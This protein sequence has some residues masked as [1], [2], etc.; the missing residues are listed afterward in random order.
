MEKYFRQQGSITV[1]MALTFPTFLAAIG[2]F[3][4]FFQVFFIQTRMETAIDTVGSKC[5]AYWYGVEQ[6]RD[7]IHQNQSG[8]EEQD[9][10]NHAETLAEKIG[11]ALLTDG[12][13]VLYVKNE[14]LKQYAVRETAYQGISGGREGISF[15]G[16]GLTED[17][18][19]LKIVVTYQVEIPFFPKASLRCVQSCWKRVWTGEEYETSAE[20]EEEQYVYVTKDGRVY[21]TTLQCTYLKL[22]ISPVTAAGLPD[23]HNASGQ[24][25]RPCERCCNENEQ[26][27]MYYVTETGECYHTM[28]ECPALTRYIEKIPFSQIGA[29]PG[30]SRCA[31]T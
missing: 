14:V 21:H 22:S 29:M 10:E 9:G 3:L 13:T 8:E 17:G 12:I 27:M 24:I 6:I 19:V 7:Y 30:C 23:A 1:E 26:C 4:F 18:H 11:A 20:D 31:N 15:L 16:S 28:L 25:Y 2:I 5:A